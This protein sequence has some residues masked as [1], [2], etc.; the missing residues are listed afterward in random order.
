MQSLGPFTVLLYCFY[1]P[2][3]PGYYLQRFLK[4]I[5]AESLLLI[6]PLHEKNNLSSTEFK[7]LE[8]IS[9]AVHYIII[10]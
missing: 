8:Y 2:I 3:I 7:F 5:L 1:S 10:A 6:K 9:Q 4:E